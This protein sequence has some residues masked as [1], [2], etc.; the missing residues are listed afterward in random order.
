VW[1]DIRILGV[2]NWRNVAEWRRMASNPDEGQASQRA[3]VPVM[4]IPFQNLLKNSQIW[5]GF[6]TSSLI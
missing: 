5:K 3:V 6:N 2:K 1:Q 4:M